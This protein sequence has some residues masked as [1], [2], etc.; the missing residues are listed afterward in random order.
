M[1]GVLQ[2]QVATRRP[3][4]ISARSGMNFVLPVVAGSGCTRLSKD[5]CLLR[6]N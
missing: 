5:E 4:S 1:A 2:S 3:A 6:L